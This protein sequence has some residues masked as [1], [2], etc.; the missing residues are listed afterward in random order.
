MIKFG[1][2]FVWNWVNVF[3]IDFHKA[4]D[5]IALTGWD[6]VECSGF[7]HYYIEHIDDLKKILKLHN[8]EM[9]A[10]NS[11]LTLNDKD[12]FSAELGTIK[13]V[14]KMIK[15][16]KSDILVLDGGIK[17][18][19]LTQS[20]Y[21]F[22]VE[23]IKEICEVAHSNNIKP[24]WHLHWGTMWDSQ[25]N[26]EYLMENTKDSGLYFCP[27]TAQLYMIGMDPLETMEKYKERISHIHFK[28]AIENE[29]I[30]RYLKPTSEIDPT[31]NALVPLSSAGTYR[32][33]EDRYLD[34]G[35]FH[36]NSKHRVIEVARGV[37][38]FKPIVKLIK[39]INF[40]GW[41]VVDQ[42]YT[43]YMSMESLDV[44][45]KN[46]MYLFS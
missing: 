31:N 28:D 20:D 19:D 44:N 6:G 27:D 33:L 18:A 30:N 24:T 29:F 23:N 41:I 36:I 39:D 15:E 5:E 8:L 12:S 3:G 46:L 9:G 43:G 32:Y 45:R 38:D 26:F 17:R 22:S 25:E 42:D 37:I 4:L 35:A 2:A 7:L 34:N 16:M 11:F 13:G 10:F 21:K 1:Y 14:A 40:N